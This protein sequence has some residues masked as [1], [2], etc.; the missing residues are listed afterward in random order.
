[1]FRSSHALM[2]A[3]LAVVVAGV[4]GDVAALTV[5]GLLMAVWASSLEVAADRA[6]TT[7]QARARRWPNL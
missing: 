5:L 3:S 1:M 4:F 6:A 7:R 2:L